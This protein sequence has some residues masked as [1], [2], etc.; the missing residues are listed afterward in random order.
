MYAEIFLYA[1]AGRVYNFI[2]SRYTIKEKLYYHKYE[3]KARHFCIFLLLL[4]QDEQ[5]ASTLREHSNLRFSFDCCLHPICGNVLSAEPLRYT[6][7]HMVDI[8][9]NGWS[10][11]ATPPP[12]KLP[13]FNIK[14]FDIIIS[15]MV[16]SAIPLTR[17]IA[18]I[19]TTN[20]IVVI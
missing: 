20:M 18:A 5:P 8:E 6:L 3:Q 17:H 2:Q 4:F 13:P 15:C 12:S 11:A 7:S 14:I 19:I 1:F 10:G 16:M 9:K